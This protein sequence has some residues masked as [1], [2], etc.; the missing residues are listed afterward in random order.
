MSSAPRSLHQDTWAPD[1]PDAPVDISEVPS[2]L[3]DLGWDDE[4]ARHWALV[5][6]PGWIPGRV[7]RTSRRFTYVATSSGTVPSMAA[8]DADPAPV[9]GD[10]VALGVG[11]HEG[12]EVVEAVLPRRSA[13]GRRDPAGT[14]AE[15]VLAVNVDWVFVVMGLDRPLKA[16]RIERSLVLAWDSGAVPVIVLTK[17]DVAEDL[18]GLVAEVEALAGD[19]AVHVVSSRSGEG[20]DGLLDLLDGHR[21]AVLLGESGAGKSTLVNRLAAEEVQRT[22]EVRSSD[23]KGRHTTVTRDLVVLATGGIIID[24]PGIRSLGLVDA[25]EGLAAA[26]P[27]VEEL[28]TR[29]RFRD[30]RHGTEP[31][32]AVVAAVEAGEMDRGRVERYRELQDELWETAEVA[33]ESQRRRDAGR[34]PPR[35]Q[36]RN[37]RR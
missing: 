15:Q 25:D 7:I 16:G 26:Y 19:A 34:E 2:E 27:D 14:G 4:V 32:C 12:S 3:V 1:P 17:A 5:A 18:E 6:R 29:C 22:A 37:R 20:L 35:R 23:A 9:S 10:W 8:V 28:A 30:C 24:T 31:G 21:T 11:E 36:P 33:V 13:L